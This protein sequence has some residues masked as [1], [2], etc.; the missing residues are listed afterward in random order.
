MVRWL[1]QQ[2]LDAGSFKTQYGDDALDDA[3]GEGATPADAAAPPS[4]APA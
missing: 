2:G 3:A 4:D 1:R